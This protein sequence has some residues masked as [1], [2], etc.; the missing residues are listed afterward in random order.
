MVE[1]PPT[2]LPPR[3]YPGGPG[4]VSP[5]KPRKDFGT[6]PGSAMDYVRF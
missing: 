6:I 3:T 5:W 2:N 4:A 1:H